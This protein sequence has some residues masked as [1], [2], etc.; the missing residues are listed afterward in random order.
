MLTENVVLQTH[1][2]CR[3]R[4]ARARPVRGVRP[5][6]L[7]AQGAGGRLPV[8]LPRVSGDT[9]HVTVCEREGVA[10][11]VLVVRGTWRLSHSACSVP[12]APG[13]RLIEPAHPRRFR[14]VQIGAGPQVRPSHWKVRVWALTV[15][16]CIACQRH[17]SSS[18][19]T[20]VIAAA[21]ENHVDER[22]CPRAPLP[23]TW[24]LLCTL[25]GPLPALP[26]NNS[27]RVLPDLPP[28]SL[29]TCNP[30]LQC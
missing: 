22:G 16:C 3:P 18:S 26:R 6:T 24:D 19:R 5:R 15:P 27:A 29:R 7:Q 20:A 4:E 28:A 11:T 13:N 8:R 25:H 21:S 1:G 17:A 14:R 12:G 10:R 2:A 30:L 9:W 23:V